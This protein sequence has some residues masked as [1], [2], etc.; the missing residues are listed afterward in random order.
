MINNQRGFSLALILIIVAVVAFGAWYFLNSK[1][2]TDDVTQALEQET[3]SSAPETTQNAPTVQKAFVSLPLAL[4]VTNLEGATDTMTFSADEYSLIQVTST[5]SKVLLC[6]S[7][8]YGDTD[9]CR[10]LVVDVAAKTAVEIG[11]PDQSPDKSLVASPDK[12]HLLL[13]TENRIVVIDVAT[14]AYRTVFTSPVGM[15]PG[16]YSCLPTFKPAAS[17]A[18]NAAISVALYDKDQKCDQEPV[19]A[20]KETRT[21]AI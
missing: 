11:F 19:P 21:V 14:L 15:V 4:T 18:N 1:G 2:T 5:P 7:T 13:A 8:H 10:I 3:V 16:T 17:W 9:G 20:P 6:P 12:K